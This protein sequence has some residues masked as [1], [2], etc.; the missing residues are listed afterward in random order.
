MQGREWERQIK[1]RNVINLEIFSK[2]IQTRVG[3]LP[4]RGHTCTVQYSTVQYKY[5][6]STNATLQRYRINPLVRVIWSRKQRRGKTFP[7][8][9]GMRKQPFIVLVKL[10]VL[11]YVAPSPPLATLNQTPRKKSVASICGGS[12]PPSRRTR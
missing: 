2:K 7:L 1:S 12:L 11:M 6:Y 9:P 8:E 3:L 10:S 5:L 4:F